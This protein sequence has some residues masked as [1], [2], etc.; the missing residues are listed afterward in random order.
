MFVLAP[1][2]F[3]DVGWRRSSDGMLVRFFREFLCV[4]W[5][6]APSDREESPVAM[7]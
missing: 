3:V 4:G 2:G 7:S 5:T 1:L 6:C